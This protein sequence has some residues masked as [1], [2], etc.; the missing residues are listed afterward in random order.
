M[1]PSTNASWALITGASAGIGKEFAQQLAAAGYHLVL[2]A[3][4]RDRLETLADELKQAHGIET[5][6]IVADLADPKAP[7]AITKEIEGAGIALEVLVNNAGYGVAGKLTAVEWKTH[8]D[9]IQV[10]MTAVVELCY[11]LLPLMRRQQYSA[12]INVASLAGLVPGSAGHTLYGAAKSFLIRFSESLHLEN[13][14]F[15]VRVQALCPGFTYSEFH[16]VVGTRDQVSRMPDYMWQSAEE[17]VRESLEKAGQDNALP[18]LVSGRVNRMIS[19]LVRWMPMRS[20]YNMVRKRSRQ[21]RA[22]Q[23]K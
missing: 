11:L 18:V 14:E 7:T 8:Q 3:R 1:K 10:M 19:R 22:D 17:V 6:I 16:D 4:R 12:I 23:P 2:T 9:F 15:G 21:F 20:A 13:E 5:R